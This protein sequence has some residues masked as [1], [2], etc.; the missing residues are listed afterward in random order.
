MSR[1]PY[2]TGWQTFILEH[3][4]YGAVLGVWPLLRPKDVGDIPQR[5]IDLDA[6][7]SNPFRR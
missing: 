3:L 1:I 5:A 4:V 7:R 6:S 2:E